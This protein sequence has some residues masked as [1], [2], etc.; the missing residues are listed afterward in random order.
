MMRQTDRN[1]RRS[2]KSF[3]PASALHISPIRI[4]ILFAGYFDF[5]YPNL[6]ES[7]K[8]CEIVFLCVN[9]DIWLNEVERLYRMV[10]GRLYPAKS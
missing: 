1:Q 6:C 8:E 7:Q 5:L 10:V 3:F 2:K 4:K 9:E